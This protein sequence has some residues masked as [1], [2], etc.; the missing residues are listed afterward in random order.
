MSADKT[1]PPPVA[2]VHWHAAAF[3]RM[4]RHF[5]L[6]VLGIS[7]FMWIFFI[8]YFH[9][10]RHPIGPVTTMPLTALDHWIGFQPSALV[11]YLSLWVYVGAP[12]ML[13]TS[14]RELVGYVLWIGS[15]CAAGLIVFILWPS[16]VPIVTPGLADHP[17]FATLQG[18]DA[19]G[20][21]CP[22]LHVATA[23]FSAFWID[24]LLR[25]MGAGLT[26]RVT[27][28]LWFV[29]IAYSTLAIKQH[30]VWDVVAGAALGVL[31]ALPSLALRAKSGV[32][33]M[34]TNPG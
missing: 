7:A 20:N 15:L 8:A 24:R 10:L 30:V 27:N 19:S 17:A 25:E 23:A 33:R 31:F 12:P 4:R 13:L 5:W 2:D 26:P 22:S 28:A 18:I 21:A 32:R 11:A 14:V 1:A 29:L 34:R 3:S 16:A 6:K 9:V